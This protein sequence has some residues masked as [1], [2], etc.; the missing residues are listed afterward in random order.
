MA[1]AAPRKTD[2]LVEHLK[3]IQKANAL[4]LDPGLAIS[5]DRGTQEAGTSPGRTVQPAVD[6][7]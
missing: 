2:H 5:D 1:S 6:S 4:M 3:V 7:A